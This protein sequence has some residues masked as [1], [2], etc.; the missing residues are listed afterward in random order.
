MTVI[1]VDSAEHHI[2]LPTAPLAEGSPVWV[3]T[4]PNL[5][6]AYILAGDILAGLGKR[7]DLAGKGRNQHLEITLATVWLR[8][9]HTSDLVITDAQRLH[10]KILGTVCRLAADAGVDLWLL[11][12]VPTS[13]AFLHALERRT[14]VTKH[15]DDV[16]PPRTL[17]NKSTAPA[18]FPTVPRHDV[19]LFRAAIEQALTGDART[20]VLKRLNTISRDAQNTISGQG[21]NAAT[22]SRLVDDILADAPDD[23]ELITAIRGIQLAAWHHD[24]FLKVDIDT[25]L[26]S[27]ERPTLPETH[28]D[29][30]LPVY[31]Q[32]HRILT[33]ALT[34]R[35]HGLHDITAL[36]LCDVHDDGAS[37]AVAGQE[38]PVPAGLA[39]AARAAL[40]LRQH[41]G[42]APS[43]P[44][45]PYAEQT[46]AAVLTDAA[47]DLGLHV[48]G[49]RAERSRPG[50]TAHLR[51]LGLT[52]V[53]LT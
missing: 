9:H 20:T 44:L 40:L 10:P 5:R 8:A 35:G 25:L 34:R 37:L 29:D 21:T 23:N 30:A 6:R 14:D 18:A 31:R 19:H 43:D 51:R 32:P 33:C 26:H 42:A 49:R 45:L 52:L 13:D 22:I 39:R 12:R 17:N 53:D 48:K 24:L 28:V 1:A 41:D 4:R 16:P 47:N 38:L 46:L 7:H 50:H 36:R 2:T 3:E 11:H 27:E 15:I